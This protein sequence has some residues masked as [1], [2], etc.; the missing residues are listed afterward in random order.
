MQA[1][2]WALWSGIEAGGV[3]RRLFTEA[4]LDQLRLGRDK[5]PGLTWHHD[6]ISLNSD[7]TGPM[8]LLDERAHKTFGHVGWASQINE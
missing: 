3:D 2:S 8:L 7:G 4:Q 5:I 6:G 1:A